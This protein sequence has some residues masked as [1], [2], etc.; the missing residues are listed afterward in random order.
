MQ[1]AIY[2]ELDG[3]FSDFL[4]QQKL[5]EAYRS[6]AERWFIPVLEK[7]VSQQGAGKSP[8]ILGI[9]GCQGSGKST[10]AA[11]AVAYF[12]AVHGKSA[13]AVSIDDFYLTV[14]ERKQ[15]AK[16]VHSLLLTRG[17]PGTH[18]LNLANQTI[19]HLINGNS[20]VKV[21]RFNKAMDDREPESNWEEV[22]APVDIVIVEGW[23]VGSSGQE[24][25][26]LVMPVN[27]LEEFEDRSGQ[28]R[29]YVNQ[30][31]TTEYA[32]FFAKIDS[33]IMLK[34]PSF[35]CVYQWRLEQEEKLRAAVKPQYFAQK[36]QIMSPQQIR[37]FIQYYQRVTEHTLASLPQSA[38]IV[39][40]MDA[41]RNI[42]KLHDNL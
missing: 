41:G 12:K 5:P 22:S 4:T 35:D 39:F 19:T 30:K 28:W 21:P 40:E 20:T 3:V 34:A 33:W 26:E 36:N 24:E 16:N 9:N 25:S 11:L 31:L 29:R 18:D 23:C 1:T 13:V 17:V 7:I 10:L 32:D 42:E 8:M 38:Q 14:A 15:L 6:T 2:N 27:E 37:R